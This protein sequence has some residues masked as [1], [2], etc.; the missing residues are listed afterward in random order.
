MRRKKKIICIISAFYNENENLVR[1]ISTFDKARVLLLKEGYVVNLV[2]VNDGSTD[3]SL[4]TAKRI[5]KKKIY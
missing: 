3:N 2:L 4:N 5:R 1:F